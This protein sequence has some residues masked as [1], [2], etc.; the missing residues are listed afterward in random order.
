MNAQN[1]VS[2]IRGNLYIYE[3]GKKLVLTDV[4]IP[5][6]DIEKTLKRK[7]GG[8]YRKHLFETDGEILLNN[9]KKCMIKYF[10][11]LSMKWKQTHF[12]DDYGKIIA[13]DWDK[14]LQYF[15]TTVVASDYPKLESII[16]NIFNVKSPF[17]NEKIKNKFFK[18]M[19]ILYDS[20][21]KEK[22]QISQTS[23]IIHSGIDYENYIESIL[24]TYGFNVSRTP[25][26]GDQGVDLVAEKKGVRIAIQCKY[27]SK[28]V[29]N[30]AVQE[31]I[32]GRDFYHCQKA[33][34]V[35][36]NSFTPS[37]RKIAAVAKVILANDN[38]I[39]E[40]LEKSIK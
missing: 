40:K 39:I 34:V 2:K 36:N 20:V 9:I 33:C 15:L 19:N 26:T 17:Y 25:T 5:E 31:V 16:F 35:T 23:P 37:A 4:N 21:S 18:Q 32:A 11:V 27:Y 6:I 3:K 22:E 8:R 10:D 13:K 14:E 30:K 29:G 1:N 12:K 24:Q 7:T 28:P 38:Q